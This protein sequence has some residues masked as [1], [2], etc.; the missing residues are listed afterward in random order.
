MYVSLSVWLSVCLLVCLLSGCMLVCLSVCLSGGLSVL[1]KT[2]ADAEQKN[3]GC[4]YPNLQISF[5]Q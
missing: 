3:R 2:M 4:V 1:V 5:I